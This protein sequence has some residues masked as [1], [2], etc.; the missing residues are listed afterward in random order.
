MGGS[1]FKISLSECNYTQGKFL[2]ILSKNKGSLFLLIKEPYCLVT[3]IQRSGF[4]LIQKYLF[5]LKAVHHGMQ[6]LQIY[7]YKCFR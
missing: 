2:S 7:F 5:H 4:F 3:N 1:K 6:I